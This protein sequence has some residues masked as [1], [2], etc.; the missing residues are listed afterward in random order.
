[1]TA[2]SKSFIDLSITMTTKDV[3]KNILAGGVTFLAIV[4]PVLAVKVSLD[5]LYMDARFEPAETLHA[6]CMNSANVMFQSEGQ[7]IAA[8]HMAFAYKPQDIQIARIS[9]TADK[10]IVNYSI[11]YD[12]FSL[13]YTNAKNK[14]LNNVNLFQ[15]SFESSENLTSTVL[16]LDKESYVLLKNGEKVTLNSKTNLSFAKVE[17]C[18][19]DEIPPTIALV[20]PQDNKVKI[21]LDRYFVFDMKDTGK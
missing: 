13:N 8:V 18:N 12:T 21:P 11:D 9:S 19:P 2:E 4:A 10:S 14:T 1:M 3:L 20:S 15:V 17:E 7:D 5:P 6:G 16:E